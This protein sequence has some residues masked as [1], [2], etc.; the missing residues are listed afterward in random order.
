[1]QR[2]A[3][4]K[5]EVRKNFLKWQNNEPARWLCVTEEGL[6]VTLRDT[7]KAKSGILQIPECLR[8]GSQKSPLPHILR[9]KPPKNPLSLNVPRTK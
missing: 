3:K 6:C 9:D 8:D 5:N 7:L 1:M 4:E 2:N